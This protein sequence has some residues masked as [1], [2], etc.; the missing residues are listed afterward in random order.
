ML[1][2][3]FPNLIERARASW[4]PSFESLDGIVVEQIRDQ[5]RIAL[6]T[7]HDDLKRAAYNEIADSE[8]LGRIE[9]TQVNFDFWITD[10]PSQNVIESI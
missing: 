6:P 5:I 2:L 4:N 10:S 7:F 3:G 8:G 9:P 1:E